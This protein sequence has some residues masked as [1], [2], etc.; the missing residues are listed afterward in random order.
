MRERIGQTEICNFLQQFKLKPER[1][2]KKSAESDDQKEFELFPRTRQQR[3]VFDSIKVSTAGP[4]EEPDTKPKPS[5]VSPTDHE[6]Y[7]SL[8]TQLT[9]T[10]TPTPIL[11]QSDERNRQAIE[12]PAVN[13]LTR[14]ALYDTDYGSEQEDMYFLL[15]FHSLSF[16]YL[17]NCFIM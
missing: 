13:L 5:T 3:Q 1:K 14:K 16:I 6:L 17:I 15:I 2:P 11:S 7:Q 10:A 9:R 4:A 12:V 8:K